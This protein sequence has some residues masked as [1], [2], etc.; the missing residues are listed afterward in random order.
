MGC[1]ANQH[2]T[3][4]AYPRPEQ[5][6]VNPSRKC[7]RSCSTLPASQE[8]NQA[9]DMFGAVRELVGIES[10]VVS[11]LSNP[12]DSGVATPVETTP[13]EAITRSLLG[14]IRQLLPAPN[15]L[16]IGSTRLKWASAPR[17]GVLSRA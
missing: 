3:W 1:S 6:V 5:L 11:G 10:G 12:N 9:Y 8:Q 13:W 4:I 7:L 17:C 16:T 14:Y 15:F 2:W